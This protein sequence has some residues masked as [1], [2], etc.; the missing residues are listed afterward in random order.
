MIARG[1]F[2]LIWL[3]IQIWICSAAINELMP[4]LFSDGFRFLMSLIVSVKINHFAMTLAFRRPKIMIW[5]S[6]CGILVLLLLTL[7]WLASRNSISS[8]FHIQEEAFLQIVATN[9]K[10]VGGWLPFANASLLVACYWGTMA[11]NISDFTFRA[12]SRKKNC[13]E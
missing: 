13:K 2:G 9:Q 5:T 10:T 8:I 7:C 12:K 11:L 6:F 1:F 4:P 3:S